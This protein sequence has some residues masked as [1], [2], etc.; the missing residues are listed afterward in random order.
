MPNAIQSDVDV[1]IGDRERE[2]HI[3]V[4]AISAESIPVVEK[5]C[6]LF[7]QALVLALSE[8]DGGAISSLHQL[9]VKA[10]TRKSAM[11]PIIEQGRHTGK[12]AARRPPPRLKSRRPK[13]SQAT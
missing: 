5:I 4:T 12:K 1:V 2:V 7:A 13:R 11:Q 8:S 3:T 9:W 6:Q 10:L